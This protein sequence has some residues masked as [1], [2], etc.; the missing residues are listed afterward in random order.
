METY[1]VEKRK[2]STI[3]CII[4]HHLKKGGGEN[5]FS[6]KSKNLIT[7]VVTRERQWVTKVKE[8]DFL[9]EN[10]VYIYMS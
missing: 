4:C 7:V 8:K 9:F 6:Q 2:K 1:E 5:L 10:H 3:L